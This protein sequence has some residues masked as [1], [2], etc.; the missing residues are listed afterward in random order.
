MAI[1]IDWEGRRQV[2]GVEMA[3]KESSTQLGR[4]SFWAG[5]KRHGLRGVVFAVSDD[6]PRSSGPSSKCPRSLLAALLCA[7]FL[8]NALDYLP[9]KSPTIA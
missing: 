2:P 1:G 3:K 4:S 5:L 7:C 6:H 9:A 8:R